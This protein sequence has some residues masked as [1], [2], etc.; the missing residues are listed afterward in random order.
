MFPAQFFRPTLFLAAGLA[1]SAVPA[2]AQR[3]IPSGTVESGVL[4]FDGR[5]TVGDF[6]G[7][8]STIT[9]QL[10]GAADLA[11]VRGWVEAPVKTLVT[12]DS[13]RDKDLNKSMES[14]KYPMIRF[15]LTGVVPGAVRG[16]TL[17]VTLRGTFLIHGVRQEVSIPATVV[18]LA[19]GVRVRGET[20][21]NLKSYRIGG[22][23]KAMGMLR[24][25]EEI[26]VHLDLTFAASPVVGSAPGRPASRT[27]T[28]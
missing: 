4:S 5:A 6:T 9:G 12:G 20:P 17:G 13:R 19:R 25:Q 8:T 15:D 3:A 2:Q 23:S 27:A 22:L 11:A 10:A 24:M 26:V 7:T 18:M 16:D 28:N 14:G 1:G 21:L